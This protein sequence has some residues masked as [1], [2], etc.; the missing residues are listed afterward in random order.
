MEK[1]N[2]KAFYNLNSYFE[3]LVSLSREE[4][5]EINYS[6]EK[7]NDVVLQICMEQIKEKVKN[8]SAYADLIWK[9]R[10]FLAPYKFEAFLFYMEKNR[11]IQKRFYLP[12]RKTLDIVVQD[13]QDLED[14][15]LDFYGLSLPPRVGKST[16]CIFFLAWTMGRHPDY[17]NAMGGHSG[18]LAKGFYK[19]VLNLIGS[20][21]YTYH[22]I[23]P[24]IVIESKSA[25]ELTVNLNSPDRFPT[26]TCRGIDGT[27]TGAVDI[28]PGGYLYVDDLIRDRTESL[29][30]IRLEN[31]FQDYLNVMVDRK[32]NGAKE[33]MVATRWN[34]MDP[35]GR[36]EA[37]YK[38]NPRYRFRKIPALNEKD[39]SNFRYEYGVGFPS[40][41]YKDMR[42]RLDKNE[43]MAKFQQQ[44]F[45]RE[46]LLFDQDELRYYNGVLPD[47]DCRIIAACDVAFGGGDSLSMP[48]GYEYENGDIYIVGWV[49]NSG[50]KEVTIPIVVGNII[51]HDVRR[52]CFEGNNG[53]A[54]YR[55]LIDERLEENHFKC[56]TSD[57]KAP[58]TMSKMEKIIAY[59]GDV[60]RRCLF[61]E[62]NKRDDE[63][64]RAMDELLMTVQIGKN[65]HD[66][67][68]DGI[69]QLMMAS[70]GGSLAKVE[71]VARRF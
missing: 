43:W 66:D 19:E 60:K 47:G 52:I 16:L 2:L 11:P 25:E 62:E 44:P 12:R 9:C 1:S 26:L 23:F 30:P 68:A 48:I 53:G 6:I 50:A 5:D 21:E 34:V 7:V 59:S 10:L 14:G 24:T 71:A 36:I 3:F 38:D 18:I 41:Y 37:K 46:G 22:E 17:H 42:S 58:S 57:R 64:R 4:P 51:K 61:L 65:V 39:V 55:Q 20:N 13:L 45:I 35:L 27:W 33:L 69:T 63:Y 32:N 56:A 31:R 15:K 70:E 67:A 8:A 54:L 28:S 49:F 29:S 40:E